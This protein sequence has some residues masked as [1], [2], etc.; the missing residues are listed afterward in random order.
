MYASLH[1]EEQGGSES[2]LLLDERLQRVPQVRIF[3][4]Q[5]SISSVHHERHFITG[6]QPFL[7]SNRIFQC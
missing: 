7:S 1:P 5:V 3:Y 2:V 6:D 4:S